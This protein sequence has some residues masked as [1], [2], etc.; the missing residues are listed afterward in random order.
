M[1]IKIR[2]PCSEEWRNMLDYP[3]GKFCEV[4]CKNVIDFA[5][6]AEI[7]ILNIIK[8]DNKKICGRISV[9]PYHKIAAGILLISNLTFSQIQTEKMS[10]LRVEQNSLN[11]TKVSGKLIFN[12]TKKEVPNAEVFFICKSKYI[13]TITNENGNFTLEIPTDLL[14]KKNILYVNLDKINEKEWKERKVLDSIDR[15]ENQSLIFSKNEKLEDKKILIKDKEF[16]IGAVVIGSD[17]P[18]DYYYFNGKRISQRK[19]ERLKKENPNFQFFFFKNK[20][21]EVISRKSY[22]GSLQLLYS[23]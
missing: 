9:N 13:K 15:Y 3:E 8:A 2:K 6:M 14:E 12:T 10:F 21:A 16:E 1:N 20:E 19:F 7:D 4:C 17:P 22:I 5:E 18:P 11:V 23:F